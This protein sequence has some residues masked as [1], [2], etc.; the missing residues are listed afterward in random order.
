MKKQIQI[1][2]RIKKFDK[3][4]E[5]SGDKSI[6]ILCVLFLLGNWKSRIYNIRGLKMLNALKSKKLELNTK[7]L[8]NIMR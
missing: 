7:N 4:M 1:E 5:V 6:S 8:K 3:V 2:E